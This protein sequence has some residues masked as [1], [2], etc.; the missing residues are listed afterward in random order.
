MLSKYQAC[1]TFFLF[2]TV[3][4]VYRLEFSVKVEI[5]GEFLSVSCIQ[6]S[7]AKSSFA[8]PLYHS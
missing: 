2:K 5:I 7:A 1:S 8:K 3:L 4:T 6:V